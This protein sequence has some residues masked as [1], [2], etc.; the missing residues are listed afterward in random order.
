MALNPPFKPTPPSLSQLAINAPYMRSATV[1][2]TVELVVQASAGYLECPGN[3]MLL[4]CSNYGR[5]RTTT[6]VVIG[7]GLQLSALRSRSRLSRASRPALGLL[8]CGSF[9]TVQQPQR[10]EYLLCLLC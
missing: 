4:H 2:S 8:S 6:A 9:R 10:V 5:N 3:R 7:L 1:T